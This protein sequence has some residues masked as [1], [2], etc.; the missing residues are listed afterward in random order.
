[1]KTVKTVKAVCGENRVR[2]G[3]ELAIGDPVGLGR[4]KGLGRLAGLRC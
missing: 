1:M 3:S 2:P 4:L